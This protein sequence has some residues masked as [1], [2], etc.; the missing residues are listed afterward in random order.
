M[1]QLIQRALIWTVVGLALLTGV[2]LHRYYQAVEALPRAQQTSSQALLDAALLQ[3][4]TVF[5]G[6]AGAAAVG[7]MLAFALLGL[8]RREGSGS[9]ARGFGVEE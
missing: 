6:A 7:A 1:K 9:L 8:R 5:L 2:G 4:H 3:V